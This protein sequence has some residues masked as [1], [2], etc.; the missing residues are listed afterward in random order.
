[1]LIYKLIFAMVA[2]AVGY[3]PSMVMPQFNP[4]A[5]GPKAEISAPAP[6]YKLAVKGDR[7]DI[8][9]LGTACSEQGWPHFETNCLRDTNQATGQARPVRIITF[10]R[11][12]K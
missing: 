4:K 7:L 11:P 6:E 9:P 8:R 12:S 1:M 2:T 3:G 5:E 10:N